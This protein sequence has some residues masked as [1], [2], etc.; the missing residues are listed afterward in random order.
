MLAV[1]VLCHIWVIVHIRVTSKAAFLSK[2][3]FDSFA[4]SVMA[5]KGKVAGKFAVKDAPSQPKAGCVG[6]PDAKRSGAAPAESPKRD[7]EQKARR[8]I[9]RNFGHV[10]LVKLNTKKV[11]GITALE[12]VMKDLESLHANG[13]LSR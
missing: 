4:I 3:R 10:D 12:Q 6:S 5:P 2:I 1:R 9:E 13:R 7:L 8:G 11:N